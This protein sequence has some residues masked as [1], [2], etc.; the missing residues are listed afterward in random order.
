MMMITWPNSSGHP[1][2]RKKGEKHDGIGKI[3]MTDRNWARRNIPSACR[4]PWCSTRDRQGRRPGCDS[5]WVRRR[6]YCQETCRLDQSYASAETAMSTPGTS[7]RS[8]LPT[9]DPRSNVRPASTCSPLL[10]HSAVS[11]SYAIFIRCVSKYLSFWFRFSFVC[12]LFYA[13]A[14]Q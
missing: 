2:R 4:D 13:P 8:L 6:R 5:S 9:C 14:L 11:A 7:R 1:K 10:S 12:F 3:A